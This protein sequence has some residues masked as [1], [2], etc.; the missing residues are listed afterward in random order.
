MAGRAVPVEQHAVDPALE[1]LARLSVPPAVNVSRSVLLAPSL[2]SALCPVS[3]DR[4]VLEPTEHQELPPKALLELSVG[5]GQGYALV[6]PCT[7]A[8]PGP[9]GLLRG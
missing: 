6:R 8:E 3:L 7:L 4:V 2:W 1:H 5:Y 9:R